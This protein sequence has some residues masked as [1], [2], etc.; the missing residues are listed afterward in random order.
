MRRKQ[1]NGT[2]IG[3]IAIVVLILCGTVSYQR[4]GL[5]K[6]KAYDELKI[7]SLNE[8]IEEQN[9]RAVDIKNLKKYTKT[10]KYI[11]EIAREKLGLVYKDEILIEPEE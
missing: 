7:K 6:E 2:G 10:K 9:E 3:I 5:E 4:I 8:K 11:E 1:K